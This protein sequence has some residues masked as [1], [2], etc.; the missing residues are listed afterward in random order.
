MQRAEFYLLRQLRRNNCSRPAVVQLGEWQSSPDAS[1]RDA[2]ARDATDLLAYASRFESW[3]HK[4]L[5]LPNYHDLAT[6]S[7]DV[8]SIFV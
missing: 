4:T 8:V 7:F 1:A 6:G 3:H 2:S 5:D